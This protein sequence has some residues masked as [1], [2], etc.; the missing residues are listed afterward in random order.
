MLKVHQ[1]FLAEWYMK[2]KPM[3]SS[4][5][6]LIAYTFI[7]I[8]QGLSLFLVTVILELQLYC[9]VEKLVLLIGFYYNVIL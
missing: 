4:S 3:K 2:F 6:H 5:I 9:L 8:M 7:L 1:C